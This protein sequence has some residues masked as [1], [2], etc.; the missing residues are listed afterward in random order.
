MRGMKSNAPDPR[1]GGRRKRPYRRPTVRSERI[2]EV[3]LSGDCQK[4]QGQTPDCNAF[5][6][7]S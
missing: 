4:I 3:H 2:L 1:E 6:K 5:S 7:F